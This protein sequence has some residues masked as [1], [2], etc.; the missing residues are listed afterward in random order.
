MIIIL[1][2]V[3]AIFAYFIAPDGS[4]NANRMTVE[5]GGEK[6]GFQMHFFSSRLNR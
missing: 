3:V 4:S 6:P 2:F 1:S 5:I